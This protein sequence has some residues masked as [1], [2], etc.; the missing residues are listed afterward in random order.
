M[1]TDMRNYEWRC[2]NQDVIDHLAELQ[3]R[4]GKSRTMQNTERY[5]VRDVCTMRHEDRTQ[6]V[7]AEG[8]YWRG[9][10]TKGFSCG[11]QCHEGADAYVR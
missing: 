7:D 9:R 4:H 1:D 2:E 3:F 11:C 10:H 8:S 6:A 5:M